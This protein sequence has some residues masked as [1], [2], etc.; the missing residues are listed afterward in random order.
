MGMKTVAVHSDVDTM[1]Q[2][3]KRAD[4][5]GKFCVWEGRGTTLFWFKDYGR[6]R[7]R[8]RERGNGWY[9]EESKFTV[10]PQ[11]LANDVTSVLLCYCDRV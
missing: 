10:T 4:E 6:V 3:V 8:E 5:A 2:H 7:E 9:D 11:Q 1:A